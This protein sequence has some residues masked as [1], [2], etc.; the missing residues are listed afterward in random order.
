MLTAALRAGADRVPRAWRGA[1]RSGIA[2]AATA[3]AAM[4]TGWMAHVNVASHVPA[5]TSERLKPGGRLR[6]GRLEALSRLRTWPL[7]RASRPS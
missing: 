3:A 1:R 2:S 7:D 6:R 4:G 5:T